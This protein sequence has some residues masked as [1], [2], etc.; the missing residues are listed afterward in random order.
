MI[1]KQKTSHDQK[2]LWA[3]KCPSL[4]GCVSVDAVD[5]LNHDCGA[6][7][8]DTCT[9]PLAGMLD[10]HR[11]AVVDSTIDCHDHIFCRFLMQALYRSSSETTK[12][13]DFGS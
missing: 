13:D 6:K 1:P 10:L 9:Y 11:H 4:I 7:Y 12:H 8:A 5:G 3:R 2:E